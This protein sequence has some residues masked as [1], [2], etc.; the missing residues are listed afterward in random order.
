MTD[1]FTQASHD[2]LVEFVS[3]RVAGDVEDAR[4]MHDAFSSG[5]FNPEARG[6][7]R[8][9]LIAMQRERIGAAEAMQILF[10]ET[11]RPHLG[12]P[13]P[14]GDNAERQLRLLA[15]RDARHRDYRED[16]APAGSQPKELG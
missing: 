6:I 9:G 8:D 16:W 5:S 11:V 7:S 15:F 13:G 12:T 10:E 1:P 4:G 3:A 14:V 2:A